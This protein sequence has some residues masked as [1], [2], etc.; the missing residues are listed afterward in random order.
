MSHVAFD[1]LNDS[2]LFDEGCLGTAF[3]EIP[4]ERVWKELDAYRRHLLSHN[5]DLNSELAGAGEQLS[6]F[7]ETSAASVPSI[8]MLKQAAL[9]FDRAVVDDPLFRLS[10]PLGAT[11]VAFNEFLGFE[12]PSTDKSRIAASSQFMRSLRPMTA[13]GFLKFVPV[14]AVREPPSELPI[15][16]SSSLYAERIPED[17][18]DW[19]RN[20]AR[21]SV[22]RRTD[23]GR[24]WSWTPDEP[25]QPSR[26]ICVSF[27][28]YV[29]AF[30]YFL[31]ASQFT[32]HPQVP[33]RFTIT[34]TLPEA[35]PPA[36]QFDLWVQQSINQSAGNVL[37][38]LEVDLRHAARSGSLLLTESSFV[39]DLLRHRVPAPSVEE[40]MADLALR[41]DLPVLQNID[42][43][44]LMNVRM[45]YGEAFQA[46]R[47]ALQRHLRELRTTTDGSIM[48]QRLE[49]LEHEFG[50]VQL[51]D[52]RREI[53]RVRRDVVASLVI[54]A[55]S[56][57]AVVPSGVSLAGLVGAAAGA[58]KA[59]SGY[60][61][62]V[63]Q[64]PAYFLWKLNKGAGK[65]LG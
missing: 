31:L 17:L 1:F 62:R 24:G 35:P 43:A 41:L 11:A 50:E 40:G 28:D 61:D 9:Y 55:A 47:L 51:A 30:P 26:A 63:R 27:D 19:F 21:V 15:T 39:G 56:L 20:R 3:A 13:A 57:A 2:I 54:G 6:I 12:G 60:L 14:S 64:H 18:R 34:Q 22:I 5:D 25:L 37:N 44:G 48:R 7:F 36:A 49:N 53:E 58:Y 65:E 4:E 46:F 10:R 52:V 23:D 59:A 42:I 38:H 45:N 8:D 33:G 16:Y 29:V 32:E